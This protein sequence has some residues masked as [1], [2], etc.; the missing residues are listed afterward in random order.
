MCGCT[1]ARIR[2]FCDITGTFERKMA[3]VRC[4]ASQATHL[5]DLAETIR[6]RLAGIGADA[7]LP[8][9]RLAESFQVVET[10]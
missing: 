1:V 2:T 8:P 9:S 6:F 4:H 3:A 7:G 10:A 5:A